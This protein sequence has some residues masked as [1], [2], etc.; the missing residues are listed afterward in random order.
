ME[1]IVVDCYLGGLKTDVL[2]DGL[3]CLVSLKSWRPSQ[4]SWNN[5]SRFLQNNQHLPFDPLSTPFGIRFKLVYTKAFRF[6]SFGRSVRWSCC[7]GFTCIWWISQLGYSG[8]T[9]VTLPWMLL[10][11]WSWFLFIG[12]LTFGFLASSSFV[13]LFVFTLYIY[14][15][16][17]Y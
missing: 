5:F 15:Y 2:I 13:V 14:L 10:T 1:S 8:F 17:Y 6:L 16:G 9:F 12:L 7:V 11:F 3:R 4:S